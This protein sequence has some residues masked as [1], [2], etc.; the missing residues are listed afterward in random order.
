MG[1]ALVF[2]M[3]TAISI[4]FGIVFFTAINALLN[5]VGSIVATS[6]IGEVFGILSVCLPFSLVQL[7]GGFALVANAI[8]TFLSARKIFSILMQL[9][10]GITA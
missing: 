4:G 5:G 3:S 1:A 10:G 7:L 8:I 2:A 9:L 6:F